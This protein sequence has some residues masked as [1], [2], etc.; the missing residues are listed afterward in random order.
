MAAAIPAEAA[1]IVPPAAD[2]TAAEPD[3]SFDQMNSMIAAIYWPQLLYMGDIL[4]KSCVVRGQKV[5]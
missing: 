3:G 1:C 2:R 5:N 4:W